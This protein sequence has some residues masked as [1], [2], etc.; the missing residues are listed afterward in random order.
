MQRATREE[1]RIE[2]KGRERS[3]VY[4]SQMNAQ[5]EGW[6]CERRGE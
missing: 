2:R 3:C 6:S 5:R 4:R 1:E